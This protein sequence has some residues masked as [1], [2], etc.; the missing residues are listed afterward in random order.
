MKRTLTLITSIILFIELLDTTI[1]YA[2][3]TPIANDFGINA[4]D[5]SL[6][7]LTYITGTCIFIPMVSWAYNKFSAINVIIITLIAF[8]IFSLICGMSSDIH[9]FSLFRFLQGAAISIAGSMCLIMLLSTCTSHEIVSTV[10]IVNIPA[11]LGTAVGPFTGAILSYYSSWRIAF[12]INIPICIVMSLVLIKLKSESESNAALRS[13]LNNPRLDWKGFLLIS[14][15][16]IMTS[17]GFEQLSKSINVVNLFIILIGII[18]CAAYVILWKIRQTH[19]SANYSILDLN[20]FKNTD[21]LYGA[22]INTIARASMCGIPVLLGIILQKLYRFSII[23]TG[24]YLAI[25]AVAGIIA[26]LFSSRIKT[27]GI[28]RAIVLLS[29]LTSLS[30]ELL[31]YHEYWVSIGLLWVPYFLLGFMMSLLYTSMNSVMY[32]TINKND[33]SNATNIASI[34]QQFG[35]GLGVVLSVGGFQ[36]LT[37]I[38]KTGLLGNNVPVYAFHE[39][40]HFLAALMMLNLIVSM[41]LLRFK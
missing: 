3:T 6:P 23:N 17:I 16:L 32:I 19:S 30:I 31:S 37:S 24:F 38:N 7:I 12:L 41:I 8:S 39:T 29:I 18:L 14:I 10:G 20:V 15:F 36:F 22:F 11:L 2:C 35:I 4:S 21:F 5:M 1:L 34:I 40:C 33:I 27:I 9:I 26:K 25:I 28:N 13:T